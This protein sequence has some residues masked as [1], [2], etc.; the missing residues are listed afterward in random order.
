M[1]PRAPG[2]HPLSSVTLLICSQFAR[3]YICHSWKNKVGVNLS[4]QFCFCDVLLC[5]DVNLINKS[6]FSSRLL[7]C[8]QYSCRD[9]EPW[10]LNV[11]CISL[12]LVFFHPC[13]STFLSTIS[14]PGDRNYLDFFGFPWVSNHIILSR[15]Q[16]ADVKMGCTTEK[17]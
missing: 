4:V 14:S 15:K 1:L 17:L 3:R 12:Y 9:P 6:A 11:K 7:L 8:F 2:Q 10:L 5:E 16:I 13:M